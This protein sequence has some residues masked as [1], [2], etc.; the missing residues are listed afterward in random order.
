MSLKTIENDDLPA[1]ARPSRGEEWWGCISF[2]SDGERECKR[3]STGKYYYLSDCNKVCDETEVSGRLN[4]GLAY[5]IVKLLVKLK[6]PEKRVKC[7]LDVLAHGKETAFRWNVFMYNETYLFKLDNVKSVSFT[8][9]VDC[10][11]LKAPLTIATHINWL[12]CDSE[13]PGYLVIA[14]VRLMKAGFA[15]HAQQLRRALTKSSFE[16]SVRMQILLEDIAVFRQDIYF[17]DCNQRVWNTLAKRPTYYERQQFVYEVCNYQLLLEIEKSGDVAVWDYIKMHLTSS[18]SN[19]T[20]KYMHFLG[21]IYEEDE[22]GAACDEP[23]FLPE[24]VLRKPRISRFLKMK[25]AK[26]A[27]FGLQRV[28][29]DKLTEKRHVNNL[30][31]LVQTLPG[32]LNDEAR[33]DHTCDIESRNR[34]TWTYEYTHPTT[35]FNTFRI[36]RFYVK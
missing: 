10:A 6:V 1:T 19:G 22:H 14:F 2:N 25:L 20:E 32:P 24:S 4:V 23:K 5:D 31:K 16:E 8:V 33:T 17:E 34:M 7:H 26:F 13:T 28:P 29:E 3:S 27:E 21:I 9:K 15:C 35:E 11:N 12:I 36:K 18:P 30:A